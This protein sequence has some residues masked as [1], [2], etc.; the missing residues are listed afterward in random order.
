MLSGDKLPLSIVMLSHLIYLV[1]SYLQ[2]QNIYKERKTHGKIKF[3]PAT[4]SK[5]HRVSGACNQDEQRYGLKTAGA[6]T[7]A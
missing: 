4:G 3:S 1:H 5:E 6:A 7:G 2:T